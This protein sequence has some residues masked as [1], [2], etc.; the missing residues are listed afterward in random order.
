MA[1]FCAN[2]VPVTGRLTG[3]AGKKNRRPRLP[4]GRRSNGGAGNR[5]SPENPKKTALSEQRGTESGTV[6]TD[7]TPIDPDL[8]KIIDAWPT[9]PEPIRAG[10]LAMIRAAGE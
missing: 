10:I 4:R 7:P 9:L 6:A 2:Q 1:R 8:A 5:T 3:G